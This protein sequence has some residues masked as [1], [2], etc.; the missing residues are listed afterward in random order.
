LV[1]L[2]H[3][4]EMAPR[5][6][7]PYRW[8]AVVHQDAGRY[9]A[10]LADLD[11]T[12]E[13][14]PKWPDPY[15]NRGRVHAAMEQF[16]AALADFQTFLES[17]SDG[18]NLRWEQAKALSRLGRWEEALAAIEAAGKIQPKAALN[19]SRK[20]F[21]LLWAGRV[22]E[23][24]ASL[25]RAVELEPTDART[26]QQRAYVAAYGGAGCR[27]VGAGLDAARKLDPDDEW[28]ARETAW[29]HA[30]VFAKDCPGEFRSDLALGLSRQVVAGDP[31]VPEFHE[32]LGLVLYR[33]GAFEEARRELLEAIR[34]YPQP[35]ASALFTLAMTCRRLGRA[36]DARSAYESAVSR[37][38]ATYPGDP[39]LIRAELES[40]RLVGVPPR[41]Q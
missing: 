28:V 27:E 10:A 6:A 3:A 4:I 33:R 13:R 11:S 38:S 2:T 41:P 7:I 8:R 30:D 39:R 24:V 25:S 20:G 14:A 22:G 32:T 21:L 17:G 16:E 19:L 34:L 12:L 15:Y 18:I 23:A 37:K 40:S 31:T 26:L 1:D 29:V 36:R 9:G 5:W 35:S